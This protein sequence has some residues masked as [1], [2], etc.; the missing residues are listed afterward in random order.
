[1]SRHNAVKVVANNTHSTGYHFKSN[2]DASSY[3]V[4]SKHGVCKQTNICPLYLD[5]VENCCRTCKVEISPD[6]INLS[7][8]NYSLITPKKVFV[9][10]T[11]DLVIISVNELSYTPLKVGQLQAQNEAEYVCYGYAEDDSEAG[12][13]L[14]GS[15][16]LAVDTGACYFN[17]VSFPTTEL[18]EKS[19]SYKGVSG[20]LVIG[21]NSQDIPVAYSIITNNEVRNDLSGETL[22]DLDFDVIHNFFGSKIFH[23]SKQTISVDA[24]LRDLFVEIASFDICE[25]TNITLLLPATKGFPYFN[26]IPIIEKLADEFGVVLGTNSKNKA[27]NSISALKVIIEN[28]NLKPVYQLFSSRIVEA[29]LNAPHIYSSFIKDSN[30]HHMHFMNSSDGIDYVVSAF[31]GEDDLAADVDKALEGMV[32][33]I[34][35]YSISSK[36]I[37]ERSFLNMKYSHQECELLYQVLFAGNNEVVKN[38]SLVYCMD[39]QLSTSVSLEEHLIKLAKDACSKIKAETLE[40]INKGLKVNLFFVPINR[41]NELT[42]LMENILNDC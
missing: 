36:L 30:Y 23:S 28:R 25:S 9:S 26:L 35:H 32:K 27:L 19:E 21:G 6:D 37:A 24:S 34:N 2:E 20:S 40:L 7:S 1:M 12:R 33:N 10:P 41:K 42:E 39:V 18:I 8:K 16:E 14:L 17:I 11:K 3:I 31:G 38:L 13:I 4:T 29:V 15:P 5:N 22:S